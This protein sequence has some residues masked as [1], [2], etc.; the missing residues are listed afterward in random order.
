MGNW[1]EATPAYGRDYTRKADVIADWK[2]D[3]DF[4]ETTTGSYINKSGA[5]RLELSVILRYDNN[6]KV[7]DVSAIK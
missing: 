5:E 1:I 6:R 3:K 2:D 7:V 4:R